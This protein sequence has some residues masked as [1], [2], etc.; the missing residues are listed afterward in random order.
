MSEKVAVTFNDPAA[1]QPIFEKDPQFVCRRLQQT[2][3]AEC[4]NK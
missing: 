4:M 1:R 2:I 3:K